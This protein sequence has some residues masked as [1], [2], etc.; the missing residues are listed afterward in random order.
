MN[1]RLNNSTRSKRMPCPAPAVGGV[2][3]AYVLWS[4]CAHLL[5]K[6]LHY[7]REM[8]SSKP[9]DQEACPSS[10]PPVAVS[11]ATSSSASSAAVSSFLSS[12]LADGNWPVFKI[13][14]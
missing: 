10:A 1:R 9:S 14:D 2:P 13:L 11:P 4:T 6:L 3:A 7:K 8:R 12:S 5:E